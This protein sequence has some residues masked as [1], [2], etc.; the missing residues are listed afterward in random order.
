M[1]CSE[2]AA[3]A[4]PIETPLIIVHS[5][6]APMRRIY[7]GYPEFDD[8]LRLERGGFVATDDTFGFV[9]DALH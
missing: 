1:A 2:A 3:H 5:V 8:W 6:G 9:I 4:Q 7:T